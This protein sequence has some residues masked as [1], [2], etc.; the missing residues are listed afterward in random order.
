MTVIDA[1]TNP[2]KS[3]IAFR[4]A[5]PGPEQD[6]VDWFLEL[7]TVKPK[8][9]ERLTIFREPCLPHGFPDLVAVI[10]KES[11][12]KEWDPSRRHIIP[13]DLR[14]MHH[15][16]ISGP[17]QIQDIERLF[18]SAAESSLGRL[19]RSEMVSLQNSRWRSRPLSKIYAIR[20]I[21]AIEAKMG[22]WRSALNQAFVNTWFTRESYIL[23]PAIPKG[24]DLINVALQQGVGVLSKELPHPKA[25]T[26][27]KPQSYV[28]WL[29][30]EWSWRI[31]QQS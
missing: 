8:R 18:G 3:G 17:S 22:E 21:V 30:N 10:W 11:V 5:R 7:R 25:M 16:A 29:F 13:A 6:L 14:L 2:P 31:A 12:A 20:R 15:L 26:V 9:G 24:T 27:A 4:R 1:I 28:S 19:L 23:I